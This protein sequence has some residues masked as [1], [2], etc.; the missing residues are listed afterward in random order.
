MKIKNSA[1]S[2]QS[3]FA[4]LIVI[5]FIAILFMMLAVAFEYASQWHRHNRQMQKR[6]QEKTSLINKSQEQ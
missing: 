1:A 5:I 6:L 2:G 3:G 4:T